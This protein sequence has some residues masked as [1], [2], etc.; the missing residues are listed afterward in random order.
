MASLVT[1]KGQPSRLSLQLALRE[2]GVPPVD[3]NGDPLGMADAQTRLRR[4][5]EGA[6]CGLL[7]GAAVGALVGVLSSLS[8]VG[9]L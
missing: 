1:S 8:A 9:A 2:L 3:E 5:A 6:A 4:R 7:V